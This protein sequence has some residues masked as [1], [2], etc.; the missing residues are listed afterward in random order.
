MALPNTRIRCFLAI[1]YSDEFRE[2]RTAIERAAS[3]ARF[4]VVSG[5]SAVGLES[6]LQEAILGELARA[7]CVIADLTNQNPNVF[8]EIGLAQAMGKALFMLVRN[9]EILS[10]PANLRGYQYITYEPSSKGFAKLT[11][12]LALALNRFRKSPRAAR[13]LA[14]TRFVAPFV[15]DWD[16]L[17]L[18]DIDNL[19][20]ELLSQ[21]GYRKIDWKT[22]GDP[23]DL[24]AELPKTDPDGYQYR[25]LWFISMGSG[26]SQR[27]LFERATV[28]PEHL[29]YI[30]RERYQ[31]QHIESRYADAT[32][33]LLIINTSA[34]TSERDFERDF[35][36]M[37]R[38]RTGTDLRIRIWDRSYLT[39]LVQQFPLVGYKYFSTEARL[40]S[41]SRK[42]YEELYEES[43]ARNRQIAQ[44]NDQLTTAIIALEEEKNLRVRAERDA[45]WKDISFSAAHKIGN[46][47]FA[48]ETSIEPLRK[49]IVENRTE[50]ALAVAE[51]IFEAVK[52][53]NDI[54]EQF[55]SLTK[56]QEIE[57][58]LISLRPV[59]EKSLQ[60]LADTDISVT[61]E[62]DPKIKVFVD[63][64]RFS[65]CVD[66]IV[67]NATHWF[68]KSEKLFSISV[69]QP[70]PVPL[71]PNLDSEKDYT[72]VRFVDNGRG[73]PV[74]SKS[75]IFDAFV[76]TREHG[77]GLGLALV[78][79]IIEGHGGGVFETGVPGKGA[80]FEVYIP[81]PIGTNDSSIN[82]PSVAKKPLVR[83]RRSVTND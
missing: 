76:T 26:N 40:R 48:I 58:K 54:V 46:P 41:D 43:S 64:N 35:L 31:R 32:A 34:G 42:T 18:A 21:L 13:P 23:I 3:E 78:R 82:K 20:R 63:P 19:V 72:L 79:R 4:R 73:V 50:E 5:D 65:E 67:R 2:L 56:A 45:V 11:K 10:V 60:S 39:S 52:K 24:V 8:F 7:D 49:R 69:N 14:G 33:T 57:P 38:R 47:V 59:L 25:E 68:D 62:C 81:S 37:S 55:K 66:E 83:K 75:R 17:S 22:E 9:E 80:D 30:L 44:L 6:T 12:E 53:A 28:D 27:E 71:P 1:S 61:I 51:N 16:R 74:D 36:N 29:S 70:A 77:T 15:I